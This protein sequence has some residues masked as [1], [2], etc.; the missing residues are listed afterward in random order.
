MFRK[1]LVVSFTTAHHVCRN[2]A[3][4]VVEQYREG[5]ST[6]RVQETG[7]ARPT[8]QF[9]SRASGALHINPC[10]G[11]IADYLCVIPECLYRESILFIFHFFLTLSLEGTNANKRAIR[12]PVFIFLVFIQY[13]T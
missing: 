13:R 1:T 11:G 3:R 9:T 5:A 2:P 12:T 4:G 6:P 8:L 7:I 10:Y